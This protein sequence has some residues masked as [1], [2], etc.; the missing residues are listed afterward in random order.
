MRTSRIQR[1][2][3]RLDTF[4]L[5]DWV[6]LTSQVAGMAATQKMLVALLLA[7]AGGTASLIVRLL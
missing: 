3:E 6:H 7:I 1:V 2:E 4:I 5:N